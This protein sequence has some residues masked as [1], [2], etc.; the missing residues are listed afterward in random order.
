MPINF[1]VYESQLENS[2]KFDGSLRILF[3]AHRYMPNAEDKGFPIFQE[4]ALE[5]IRKYSDVFFDIIGDFGVKDLDFDSSIERFKFHG[6]LEEK[7]FGR[8]LNETHIILSPNQPFILNPGAYDGFP[9]GSCIIASIFNNALVTSDYFS[10]A[11]NYNLI[12]DIDFLKIEP[13]KEKII[14]KVQALIED[15]DR[16]K[17]ISFSGREKV[18]KAYSYSSQIEKRVD[19]FR[20]IVN[21]R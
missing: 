5:L 17:S 15:R 16:L 13:K 9:L 12:E 14:P 18:Y 2:K 7:E 21:K 4:V 10:E 19:L 11:K 20:E 1:E 8:V 3:M 6:I